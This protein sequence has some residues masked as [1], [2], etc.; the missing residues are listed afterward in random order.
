MEVKDI[1][2]TVSISLE[3]GEFSITVSN[4]H[5]RKL[6]WKVYE[7]GSKGSEEVSPKA[8]NFIIENFKKTEEYKKITAVIREATKDYWY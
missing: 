4:T 6:Y 3:Y 7:K 5:D 8:S 1:R 2:A